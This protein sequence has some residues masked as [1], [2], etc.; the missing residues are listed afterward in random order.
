MNSK[1]KNVWNWGQCIYE[2]LYFIFSPLLAFRK[3]PTRL[4][5]GDIRRG[6]MEYFMIMGSVERFLGAV[7]E[8]MWDIIGPRSSHLTGRRRRAYKKAPTITT[9]TL[10]SFLRGILLY[11]S[12]K[13]NMYSRSRCA[14]W[15]PA[16]VSSMSPESSFGHPLTSHYCLNYYYYFLLL[17]ITFVLFPFFLYSRNSLIPV[18][19]GGWWQLYYSCVI[20][21]TPTNVLY[22]CV[23]AK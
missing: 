13:T 19:L 7:S 8:D 22:L 20:Y 21:S 5:V 4:V 23:F 12:S 9:Y 14:F 6:W 17:R 16:N 11:G 10:L 18:P 2:A 15:A 1:H 3:A